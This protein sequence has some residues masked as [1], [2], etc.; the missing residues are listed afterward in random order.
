MPRRN[1]PRLPPAIQ[2]IAR[3][4]RV[5]RVEDDRE[6]GDGWWAYLAPGYSDDA[7]G[8]QV[9]ADTPSELAERLD[10]VQTCRCAVCRRRKAAAK[11]APK[12]S[13]RGK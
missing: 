8:H 3:D 7:G 5:A 10:Y 9:H 13:S 1:P 12:K 2:T 4:P 6:F 11:P